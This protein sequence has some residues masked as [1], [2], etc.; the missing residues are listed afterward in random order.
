MERLDICGASLE[1]LV[2]G[3]GSPLLFLHQEQAF[4]Q[5]RPFLDRLAKSYRVVAPRLPG[6]GGSSLPK[7]FRTVADLALLNL[8][9]MDRLE[10]KDP[11]VVGS[12]FGGWIAT[13][14]AVYAPERI[15]R[16][17]LLGSVGVKLGGREDR[18]FADIYFMPDDELNR[19][20]YADPVRWAPDLANASEAELELAARERQM[21]ALFAWRPYMHNPLLRT[22]LHR[23]RMRTLL[24]WGEKDGFAAPAYAGSLAAALPRAELRMVAQA[25]HFPQVEQ[26]DATAA[27][28]E[29]FAQS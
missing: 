25:G 29:S 28:V 15:A 11:V 10:L 17:A 5:N 1:V 13:E 4:E 16:L 24:I 7:T 6:F 3:S 20:L 27:H 12:S 19:R 14:M 18:D 22:W 2:Q 8:D 9:L 26:A 23:V 21:F